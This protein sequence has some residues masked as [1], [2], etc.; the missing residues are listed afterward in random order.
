MYECDYYR[1]RGSVT[2][3]TIPHQEWKILVAGSKGLV[4]WGSFTRCSDP[5]V[6]IKSPRVEFSGR[7]RL[8]DLLPS[9][10]CLEESRSNGLRR[11]LGLGWYVHLLF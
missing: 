3:E 1:K 6:V 5:H 4:N 9:P 8:G 2:I 7:Y 10:T 11:F